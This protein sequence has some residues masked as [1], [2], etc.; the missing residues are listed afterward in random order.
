MVDNFYKINMI[1]K[2][3]TIHEEI[4]RFKDINKYSLLNEQVEPLEE[5][6]DD[7]GGDAPMDDEIPSVDGGEAP[8]DDMG[9][10]IPMDGEELPVDDMGGE[11]GMEGEETEEVD[12][13]DLVNM[14]KS[15]KNELDDM[16][17]DESNKGTELNNVFTKLDAF[18]QS[19]QKLDVLLARIDQMDQ[20][21]ETIKEPTPVEKLEMRSLDSYPFNEKPEEFF[22]HKQD[23]MRQSGK[24]EYILT[25]DKIENYTPHEINKS[26]NTDEN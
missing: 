6:I 11:V 26:F 7:M 10:E 13:T 8:M 16:K 4:A 19:F 21:I 3:L 18:E 5:P 17:K 23:E 9:G 24:N 14:T 15:I 25:K 22:N 1:H 12:I 20:K 2:K